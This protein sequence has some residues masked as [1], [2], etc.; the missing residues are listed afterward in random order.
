[1]VMF[2]PAY[3]AGKINICLWT[4]QDCNRSFGLKL[5]CQREE[6]FAAAQS[7]KADDR[8]AGAK[9]IRQ[10]LFKYSRVIFTADSNHNTLTA[11][12]IFND[13]SRHLR[14]QETVGFTF[15]IAGDDRHIMGCTFCRAQRSHDYLAEK[16]RG[17]RKNLKPLFIKIEPVN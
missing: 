11:A 15:E 16:N 10:Y 12:A 5:V 14:A 3:F 7:R 4:C 1:M 13:R 9:I 8:S 17:L 6:I 2:L